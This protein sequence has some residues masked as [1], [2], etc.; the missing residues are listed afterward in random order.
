MTNYTKAQQLMI[1]AGKAM[2]LNTACFEDPDYSAERMSAIIEVLRLK[3]PNTD[4]D[5][6]LDK[7]MPDREAWNLWHWLAMG[8]TAEEFILDNDELV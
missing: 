2:K 6:M 7:R 1:H 4:I 5:V 8:R 3:V